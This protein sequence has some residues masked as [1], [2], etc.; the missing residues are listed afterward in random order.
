MRDLRKTAD[1]IKLDMNTSPQHGDLRLSGPPSGQGASGEAR[2]C[3]RR[4]P[5]DHMADL[6]SSMPPTPHNARENQR[7]IWSENVKVVLK[8]HN[9]PPCQKTKA[10]SAFDVQNCT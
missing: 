6:L 7:R 8:T 3:D 9:I 5:A 10:L 1:M 2:L 4:V